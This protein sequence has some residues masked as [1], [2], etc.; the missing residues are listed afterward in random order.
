[1]RGGGG[2]GGETS[3]PTTGCLRWPAPG[4]LSSSACAAGVSKCRP[5]PSLAASRKLGDAARSR[6]SDRDAPPVRR[7]LRGCDVDD[8]DEDNNEE[9]DED[10]EE[11]VA[12]APAA[13][14]G[15][16]GLV[17]EAARRMNDEAPTGGGL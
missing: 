8:D 14:V 16:A 2:G 15:V 9:E 13:A 11:T 7:A 3:T 17:G 12:V 10:E 6:G 4:F 5:K 1:M